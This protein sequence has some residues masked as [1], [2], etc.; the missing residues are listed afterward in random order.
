V[1]ISSLALRQEKYAVYIAVPRLPEALR[2]PPFGRRMNSSEQ[3]A[4]IRIAFLE[5]KSIIFG[6]KNRRRMK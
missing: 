2:Y 5:I 4:T 1:Y 3:G 6:R